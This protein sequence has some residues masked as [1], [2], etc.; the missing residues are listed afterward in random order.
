M[1]KIGWNG[2][3]RRQGLLG[4]LGLGLAATPLAAPFI[5]GA[6]AAEPIRIGLV[7]AKQG[8]RKSVV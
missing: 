6:A 8:D 1:N 7:L 4:T 3:T 5:G 2:P